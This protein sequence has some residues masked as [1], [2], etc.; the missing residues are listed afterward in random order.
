MKKAI[1]PLLLI[2]LTACN[3]TGTGTRSDQT[4]GNSPEASSTETVANTVDL[5]TVQCQGEL[6]EVLEPITSGYRLAQESDFVPAI[7]N[8]DPDYT[9]NED[10]TC[11]IFTD[12]FTGDGSPDYALLLV[13]EATA[14]FRAMIAVNEG[15][16]T[17]SP[18]VLK[19]Y[20]RVTEPSEGVIYTSLSY[21]PAGEEGLAL[22]DYA[23]LE[24]AQR[25]AYVSRPAIAL[26]RS[27]IQDE[28]G[29]PEDVTEL[30]TLA[31]CSDAYYFVEGNLQTFQ[32]CD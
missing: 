28:E 19:E 9:V 10:F 25:E 14:D 31:Y 24:P 23:R 21:K 2:L 7:R 8:F 13:N 26:W 6:P 17:F 5:P 32:V 22:R 18:L 1:A 30:S 11:S 16:G 12:D 27:I 20:Q 3:G 29:R 4:V 15:N